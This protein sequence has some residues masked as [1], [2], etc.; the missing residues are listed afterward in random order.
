MRQPR[1]QNFLTDINIAAKITAAA[2]ISASDKIFEI[3]P[4]KGALTKLIAPLAKTLKAIEIEKEL[5]DELK[6]RFAGHNNTEIIRADFLRYDFNAEPGPLKIVSNLPYNV[7]T[8]IIEKF[9]PEKNWATAVIM[10]QK[11]VGE[12][13][14][15]GCGTKEYG[16]FTI[17]C[18]HY[19]HIKKLFPVNPGCFFPKPKVDSVVLK[20][21]NLFSDRLSTVFCDFIKASFSQRRKTALNS[22]ASSLKIE[23]NLVLKAFECSGINPALRPENLAFEQFTTLF[24]H[25]VL[26]RKNRYPPSF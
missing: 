4:G 19:A 5:Y 1:G 26:I 25:L 8:A 22:I 2:E 12:R 16:A 15:A 14:R 24:Q 13:L 6:N 21:T 7:S 23:K 10:V 3:G 18:S 11:E 17:L 9:L 20:F